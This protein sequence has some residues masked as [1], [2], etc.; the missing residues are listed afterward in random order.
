MVHCEVHL[1][2]DRNKLE[3]VYQIVSVLSQGCDSLNHWVICDVVA[4][5]V[6]SG[7]IYMLNKFNIQHN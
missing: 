7:R 5:V 4:E 3:R 2:V 1:Q 6:P